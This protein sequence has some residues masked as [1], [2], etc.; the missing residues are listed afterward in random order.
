MVFCISEVSAEISPFSFFYFVYLDSLS[1]LL[2][3]PGQ[4]FVN[5]VYPFKEPAL[6]FTDFFLLFF[7]SLFYSFPP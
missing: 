7:K 3:E 6:V 1:P 5:F 4:R 2:G